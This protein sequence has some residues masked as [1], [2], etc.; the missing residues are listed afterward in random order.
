MSE[1]IARSIGKNSEE[2]EIIQYG[3][4]QAFFMLINFI[5]IIICGLLWQELIFSLVLLPQFIYKTIC[6]RISCWYR[7]TLLLLSV[8]VMNLAMMCRHIWSGTESTFYCIYW[9][10]G[11]FIWIN[12]PVTNPRN[13]LSETEIAA[14]ANKTKMYL[15][16]FSVL[17]VLAVFG[18]KQILLDGILYAT[19]CIAMAM[20]SGKVKYSRKLE[21]WDDLYAYRWSG[22]YFKHEEHFCNSKWR[23][24]MIKK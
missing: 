18:K 12:A 2:I 3:L 13:K 15:I 8:G 22:Y 23:T 7:D 24:E 9:I 10:A 5:T 1:K 21:Q 14:Y 19:L 17:F 11:I 16:I 4:H 20:I 6:R